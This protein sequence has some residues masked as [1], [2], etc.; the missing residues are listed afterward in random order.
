MRKSA[1]KPVSRGRRPLTYES[2]VRCNNLT[3]PT[4]G[5][6]TGSNSYG[7]VATFTCDP[8]YKL[9]GTFTLTCQYD[10]TWS[11]GSPKCTAVQCPTLKSPANGNMMGFRPYRESMTRS[12][13]CKRGYKLAGAKSIRCHA[14]GTWSGRVPTCKAVQCPTLKSPANGFMT[15]TASTRPYR[16]SMTRS[17]TCKRGYKLAGAKSIR[18]QADGTWS[19][20]V[21]TC[22]AECRNGYQLLAQTCIRVYVDKKN[23]NDAQKACEKEGAT[24]AMPKTKKLD[25]ALRKLISKSGK[26][27]KYWIGLK[28]GRLRTW[29]WEDGSRLENG[30]KGWSPG[31]PM[32]SC[33]TKSVWWSSSPQCVQYWSAST[34]N[35]MW[36]DAECKQSKGY[37]CQASDTTENH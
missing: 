35:H 20:R 32:S 7:D 5:A 14:D 26:D 25:V 13:T 29:Q 22:K 2:A 1:R 16:E 15:F 33:F 23:Y 19:G 30:Y 31:E 6:M 8:G 36:D 17:F 18:C 24:L 9:V 21:P 3:P 4:N 37:I 27:S 28:T 12:F 11:G 34:Y 10:G